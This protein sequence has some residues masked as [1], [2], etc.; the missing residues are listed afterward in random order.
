MDCGT[1]TNAAGLRERYGQ[2]IERAR[3]K[4][5]QMLKDQIEIRESAEEIEASVDDGYRTRLY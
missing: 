1:V 5:L 3:L 4:S 2:P